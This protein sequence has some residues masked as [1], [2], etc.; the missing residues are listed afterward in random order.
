MANHE[1]HIFNP[2]NFE[3]RALNSIPQRQT[4]SKGT[5]HRNLAKNQARFVNLFGFVKL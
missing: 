2:L 4:A 5:D 1:D 3:F